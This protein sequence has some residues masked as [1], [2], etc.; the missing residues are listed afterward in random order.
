MPVAQE[1]E[2]VHDT[3]RLF[4]QIQMAYT[5]CDDAVKAIVDQ[6]LRIVVKEDISVEERARAVVTIVDALFPGRMEDV[7]D[8]IRTHFSMQSSEAREARIEMEDEEQLFTDRVAQ[9]M[10]KANVTQAVLAKKVGIG[11]PAV[12]MLLNRKC[13]PQK[14]TVRKIAKALGVQADYLWPNIDGT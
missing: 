12:S 10:K 8:R 14:R 1:P 4:A 6:L 9:C 2:R 7:A 3:V 5:E 13:R 11:Q